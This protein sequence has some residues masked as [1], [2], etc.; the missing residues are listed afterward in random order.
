MAA[1]Q[2]RAY[3]R[4]AVRARIAGL[5]FGVGAMFVL[6]GTAA[7]NAPAGGAVKT[8]AAVVATGSVSIAIIEGGKTGFVIMAVA[9]PPFSKDIFPCSECHDGKDVN[10]KRRIVDDHPQVVF[11]HDS[12][13][14]WCLDCHD[15]L[16]RDKLHLADGRLVD[17]TQSYLLC[18]QCHGPTLRNW[19]AGEHGKRTGMW[20][21]P[22]EYRL[23]VSCHDPHSPH[24]KQLQP[25]PP[26][27][28]QGPMP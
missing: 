15:T 6:A 10:T 27:D 19:K 13:N 16:N 5:A 18:G 1:S 11:E 20:N 4:R 2:G 17:F 14:R 25:L 12:E 26:P 9:P 7:T 24:F 21:G 23:C 28:H 8:N 22:K 3:T